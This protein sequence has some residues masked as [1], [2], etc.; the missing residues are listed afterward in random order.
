M[1]IATNKDS[2]IPYTILDASTGLTKYYRIKAGDGR[3]HRFKHDNFILKDVH[4]YQSKGII[5]KSPSESLSVVGEY[6]ISNNIAQVTVTND[7]FLALPKSKP[8]N[9]PNGEYAYIVIGDSDTP[10][11]A[12]AATTNCTLV[13]ITTVQE[14]GFGSL[15]LESGASIDFVL[16]EGE[17]LVINSLFDLAQLNGTI[18]TANHPI[19]VSSGSQCFHEGIGLDQDCYHLVEQIPPLHEWGTQFAVSPIQNTQEY[20]SMIHVISSKNDTLVTI[21]CRSNQGDLNRK[22]I[23]DKGRLF[24]FTLSQTS[25]CW[26]ESDGGVLVMQYFDPVRKI[27]MMM[28]P[29]IQQYSNRFALPAVETRLFFKDYINVHIPLEYYQPDQIFIDGMSF[30]EHKL[31]FTPIFNSSGDIVVYATYVSFSQSV[32]FHYLY[33]SDNL[34]RLG[35]QLY[36]GRYG[37]PGALGVPPTDSE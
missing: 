10:A 12:V 7:G 35:V 1:Y 4:V 25:Y 19:S 26:I 9:P 2:F 16:Q 29:P 13:T 30:K 3:T 11:M 21:N 34:A 6:L 8:S 18:I 31:K 15:N 17:T 5:I 24:E 33:H 28:V 27:F 32:K 37:Y 22:R 23:V 14:L 20:D 36:G